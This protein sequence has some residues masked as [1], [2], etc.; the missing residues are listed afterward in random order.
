MSNQ[1]ETESPKDIRERMGLTQIQM[2]I[3]A[4]VGL[5]TIQ[6]YEAGKLIN[7]HAKVARKIAAA[8]SEG[9][10]SPVTTD[11]ALP[12]GEARADQDAKEAKASA[13]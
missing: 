11:T 1:T 7:P 9:D 6:K 12:A 10:P 2:A 4:D 8:Y 5:T 13:A 3:R